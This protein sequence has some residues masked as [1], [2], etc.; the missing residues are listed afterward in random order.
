[1]SR[2]PTCPGIPAF[3]GPAREAVIDSIREQ[4]A[5]DAEH[6]IRGLVAVQGWSTD[7]ATGAVLGALEVLISQAVDAGR[8]RLIRR[9][10]VA[11]LLDEGV[12]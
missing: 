8:S 9:A 3:A 1:M 10:A 4:L 7:Q 12:A 6:Q 11:Q 5:R 2:T